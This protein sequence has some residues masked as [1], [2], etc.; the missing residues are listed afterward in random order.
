MTLLL[1]QYRYYFFLA[2]NNTIDLVFMLDG[3][4]DVTFN[5]FRTSVRFI[6]KLAKVFDV[7]SLN[8]HVAFVVYAEKSET[9]FDISD[10][11]SYQQVKRAI[12]DVRYPNKKKRN[13]GK[14]LKRVK[15]VL[16]SG[17]RSGVPKIVIS[18]QHRK[19]DDGIDAISQELKDNGI[20]VFGLGITNQVING[21]VK[22]IA[23]KPN[24]DFF[25]LVAYDNMDSHFFVQN[26]KQSICK[27]KHR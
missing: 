27:G 23:Y 8:A 22:E 6:K 15:N 20:K 16:T 9:V 12:T 2:C 21:Q 5:N 24:Q 19:S 25:H 17:G 11:L 7:S 1:I 14:G 18:V 3:S 26:I 13:V 4:S 10:H